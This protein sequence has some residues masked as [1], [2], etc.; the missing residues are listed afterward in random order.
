MELTL[1]FNV[2]TYKIVEELDE[3]CRERAQMLELKAIMTNTSLTSA[4]EATAKVLRDGRINKTEHKSVQEA[5]QKTTRREMHNISKAQKQADKKTEEK[6]VRKNSL[7][8]DRSPAPVT[9]TNGNNRSSAPSHT[10][11]SQRQGNG[12]ELAPATKKTRRTLTKAKKISFSEA[13]TGP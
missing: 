8:G 5:I 2:I 1:I 3:L 9:T 10:S 4:A 12:V 13:I 6:R 7:A 11:A